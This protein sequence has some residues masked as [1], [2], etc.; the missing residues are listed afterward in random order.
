MTSTT[1]DATANPP[2]ELLSGRDFVRARLFVVGGALATFGVARAYAPY[3]HDGPVLCMLRGLTGLPC[4]SCGLTRAFCALSQGEVLSALAFNAMALPLAALLLASAVIA[5]A[6]LV[7]GA[8]WEFYRRWL[9]S[10]TAA[11][12]AAICIAVYHVGRYAYWAWT[13]QLFH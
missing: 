2:A 3:V 7:R 4:P 13:G 9:Y 8:R 12:V 11:K 10:W 5:T 1:S 6:E